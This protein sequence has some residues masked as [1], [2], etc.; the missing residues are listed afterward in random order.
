M[1][2]SRGIATDLLNFEYYDRG[3]VFGVANMLNVIPANAV[4]TVRTL[5]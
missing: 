3:N 5:P 1:S 2:A 4:P